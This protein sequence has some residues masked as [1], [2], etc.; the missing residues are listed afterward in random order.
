MKTI[1]INA[2]LNV[3]S[4]VSFFFFL[5]FSVIAFTKTKAHF[6]YLIVSG[7]RANNKDDQKVAYSQFIRTIISGL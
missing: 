6:V 1:I 4:V 7:Y 3:L 5:L 2:Y